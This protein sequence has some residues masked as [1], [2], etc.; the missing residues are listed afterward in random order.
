MKNYTVLDPIKHKTRIYKPGAVLA[1][2]DDVA[3]D[4]LKSGVI[5]PSSE[6]PDEPAEKTPK[7]K[8]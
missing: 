5:E 6:E 3:A 1:L 8:K 2:P 4:L 7:G